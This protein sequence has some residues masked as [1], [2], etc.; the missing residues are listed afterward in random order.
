MFKLCQKILGLILCVCITACTSLRTVPV[1]PEGSGATASHK[2]NVGDE[3]VV[4]SRSGGSQKMVINAIE[5]NALLGRV[6]GVQ[7]PVRIAFN[8]IAQV[9]RREI[10]ALKSAVLVLLIVVGGSAALLKK[11]AFF[12]PAP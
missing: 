10:D 4:A 9:E 6:D 1:T 2:L 8:D 12:P 5:A 7:Q 11:A 3:I